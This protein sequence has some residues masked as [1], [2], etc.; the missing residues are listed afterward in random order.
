[1]PVPNPTANVG[2]DFSSVVPSF[3]TLIQQRDVTEPAKEAS[4][5]WRGSCDPKLHTIIQPE[6][7]GS[8][9]SDGKADR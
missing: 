4:I 5:V 8:C 1:M 9:L 2:E 6:L 3:K 7:S